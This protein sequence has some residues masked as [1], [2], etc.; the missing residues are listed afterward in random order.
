V[1]LTSESL[2]AQDGAIAAAGVSGADWP[3]LRP[4]NAAYVIYT[5]GSTG[6]P[7]GTCVTH[8]SIVNLATAVSDLCG[9]GPGE[10]ILQLAPLRFDA[11]LF[12]LCLALGTGATLVLPPP[13]LRTVGTDLLTILQEY[14]ITCA[15]VLSSALQSLP[16]KELPHLRTLLSGGESVPT[17][18]A[19]TWSRGRRF[20]IGYGPTEAT[21]IC[22]AADV[23]APVTLPLPI[24]RPVANAAVFVL[25]GYLRPVPVGVPG[26]VYIGGAGIAR[27]YVNRPELTAERF[28]PDPF[29]SVPGA[30]LYRTGDLAH[31]R[32]D[33]TVEFL[34]RI[35][36]Q[37]K[38][39][40]Y[41]VDCGEVEACLL[42]DPGVGEAA[43]VADDCAGHTR[44]VGYLAPAAGQL[45][46]A[47][48]RARLAG[49]LPDYM[50]PAVFVEML[51]LP[52]TASGKID[53]VGLPAPDGQRPALESEFA[54]AR[55]PAEELIAGI[56]EE[57]IGLEQ[58]GIH[59]N[60][61]D[62]GG[63][64][65]LAA[66]VMARI[67]EAFGVEVEFSALFDGPTVE[68][69]AYAVQAAGSRPVIPPP[70]P[71]A[72]P[73]A[74]D[75][76]LS[77]GQA[78][79]WL[80]S[81]L[82]G[83]NPFYNIAFAYRLRGEVD[84]GCL[85]LAV[86]YVIA[87]HDALRA[88]FPTVAGQPCQH[89][90]PPARVTLPV[91]D[92]SDT[93]QARQQAEHFGREAFDLAR[94]PLIRA[95]L[96]RLAADDYVFVVVTHHIVS[97]GIS[98]G[99]LT[100]EIAH[101]YG[102]YA[103]DAAPALP[104]LA[105]QYT[106]Y[107][108]WQRGWLAGEILD[109]HIEWWR[110]QLD[111]APFVLNLPTD[112]PRPPVATFTGLTHS[113]D[114]PPQLMRALGEISRVSSATLFMTLLAG[115][116][117]VLSQWSG[118]GEVLVGSPV[119]G[120]THRE[121]E[122]LI[123]YF[124]NMVVLRADCTGDPTF[125]ELLHRVRRSTLGAYDHQDLPFEQLVKQLAPPRELGRNP[126]VQVIFQVLRHSADNTPAILPLT[127]LSTESF[128]FDLVTIRTDL[129]LV[130]T[131]HGDDQ[132]T[133]QVVYAT[134][135]FDL[136]TIQRL[137][138]QYVRLLETIAANSEAL[139]SDALAQAHIVRPQPGNVAPRVPDDR[140]IGLAMPYVA[141][142]TALEHQVAGVWA[143]VLGVQHL[144]VYDDFFHLGG[145]ELLAVEAARR[146]ARAL[147]TS[148]E[149]ESLLSHPTIAE[150]SATLLR[151]TD[152]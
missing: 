74:G 97:D 23:A 108:A 113:F 73:G 68:Q 139:L 86:S 93:V 47:G 65:T 52:K 12:D 79:L 2:A 11:S 100:R 44:L 150:F 40:G 35:D 81:E 105:V 96:L 29:S 137:A 19:A 64:S 132:W 1:V 114:L 123:G 69:L 103:R 115:F 21:V 8:H 106:D 28:V 94:G 58:V 3:A 151:K 140:P 138:D 146:T 70:A 83:T 80:T 90:S 42:G 25:D 92:V 31:W 22:T 62:L 127:G 128:T 107:A 75:Y 117:A 98:M 33:D 109:N 6:Q 111:G 88:S 101:A 129:E 104:A 4:D 10:R 124:I 13:G 142:R 60:F 91:L 66:Q 48:I 24:G 46:L 143:Y 131:D 148:V 16:Y 110:G 76:P 72:D 14:E 5:S 32:P 152:R 67:R 89:I 17:H 38:I 9:G 99:I 51:E 116:Q 36:S 63:H 119:A 102:V 34:G 59:D 125:T 77:F 130:I 56:W 84:V 120:R 95:Q 135:L 71:V 30:R 133:G 49:L 118:Q 57:V 85:E 26:E 149:V 141:P 53:R 43:V 112:H 147:D 145:T 144:G 15:V 122:P 87:R 37:V 126:L 54:A 134:D 39:R 27:G 45:D 121:L 55:T 7:K 78:G 61:F 41:R 136:T 82:A 20:V 18:I 50:I